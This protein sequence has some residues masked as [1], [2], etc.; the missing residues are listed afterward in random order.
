LN[1]KEII[2][3]EKKINIIKEIMPD[4][5]IEDKPENIDDILKLGIP[6]VIPVYNYTEKY[7]DVPNCYLFTNW[8]N[9]KK[10]LESLDKKNNN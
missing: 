3:S 6:V 4:V 10:I 1:Y 7:R 9:L 8:D 2:L 5:A